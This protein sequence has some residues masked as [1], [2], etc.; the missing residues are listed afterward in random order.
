MLIK[1]ELNTKE[2]QHQPLK[3]NIP[4]YCDYRN[5]KSCRD[6]PLYMS[7]RVT[8]VTALQIFL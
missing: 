1:I 6:L 4:K 3:I 7:L 8:T 2:L 5:H